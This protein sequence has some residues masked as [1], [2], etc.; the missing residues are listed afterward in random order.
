MS[1]V[2]GQMSVVYNAWLNSEFLGKAECTFV[3][4]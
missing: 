3:K 4:I 2:L 1:V